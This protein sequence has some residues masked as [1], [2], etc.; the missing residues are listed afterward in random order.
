MNLGLQPQ[1]FQ[2][3]QKIVLDPLRRGGFTLYAFGSRATG[4][5][6]PFSDLDLLLAHP[7]LDDAALRL[8]S[9]VKTAIEEARFPIRVD[10]VLE[11]QLAESFRARVHAEKISLT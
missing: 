10:F 2:T 5:N 8:L 1:D 9:D 11:K 7:T 3:L 4:K 6:H